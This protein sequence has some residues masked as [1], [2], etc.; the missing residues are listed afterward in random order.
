M[1]SAGQCD[2]N[3]TNRALVRQPMNFLIAIPARRH[4]TRL[5][6]KLLLA[7]TGRTVL[8]HTIEAGQRALAEVHDAEIWVLC[9]DDALA[10]AARAAGAQVVMVTEPCESGTERIWRALGELPPTDIIV[11]LQADEPDMPAAWIRQ[12]VD[13]LTSDSAADLATIAL[14]LS[15]DHPGITDPNQ[16]KVVID[17]AGRALYFSRAPI[18]FLRGGG[19]VPEPRALGHVGLYAY[20]RSFLARYAQL[21]VSPLERAECLEQLRFV[22]AGA[23][24]RVVVPGNIRGFTRGIDTREDYRAFVQRFQSQSG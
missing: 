4:S 11:N 10:T 15:A 22:Q 2:L 23:C 20:R 16:V 13:S 24:I 8:A 12:C 7:E 17:H 19:V 3:D 14:P 5:P 1:A 21:A 18:P 6:E 9:D